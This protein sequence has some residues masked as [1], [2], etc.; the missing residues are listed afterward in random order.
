MGETIVFGLEGAASFGNTILFNGLHLDVKPGWTCLLGAS[1]V[2]KTTILRLFAGRRSA[3]RG[4]AS[5]K[6]ALLS[7]DVS[8]SGHRRSDGEGAGGRS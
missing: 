1:G 3:C 4:G 6:R 5:R 8:R 2:G 7:R